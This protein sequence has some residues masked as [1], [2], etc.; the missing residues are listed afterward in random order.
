M[1]ICQNNA[2][3]SVVT[4]PTSAQHLLVRGRRQGDIEAVF[5][6]D[7]AVVTLPKRDYRFRAAIPRA[8]VAEAL[9]KSVMNIDY[10]NFK[11]SVRDAALH[12]AYAT[13]WGVMAQLQEV[14]P[15]GSKPRPGFAAHP[16]R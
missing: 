4:D 7:Y 10:G 5:G 1:W 8:V 13:V 6:T 11:N 2:F 15:Y 14:P 3:L 9:A 12:D 16:V